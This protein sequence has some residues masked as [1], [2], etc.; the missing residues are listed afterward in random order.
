[1]VL[2]AV[3]GMAYF[4]IVRRFKRRWRW[5]KEGTMAVLATAA[6]GSFFAARYKAADLRGI[7]KEREQSPLR[8]DATVRLLGV[9]S[10]PLA[11][12]RWLAREP[13]APAGTCP[14]EHV[15]FLSWPAP[16]MMCRSPRKPYCGGSARL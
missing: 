16:T 10:F 8:F 15:C 14:R 13:P 2:G 6:A 4:P 5:G 1:M 3:A 9:I 11:A 12:G 7:L